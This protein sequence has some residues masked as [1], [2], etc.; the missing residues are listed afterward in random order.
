MIISTLI[1]IKHPTFR[2]V[3]KKKKNE[4]LNFFMESV[5]TSIQ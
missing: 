5:R 2:R 1:D 3:D 4:K